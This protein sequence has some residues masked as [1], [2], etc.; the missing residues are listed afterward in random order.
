MDSK[1]TYSKPDGY[2][3]VQ[4]IH[5]QGKHTISTLIP[6]CIVPDS[7]IIRLNKMLNEHFCNSEELVVTVL[8]RNASL[9][10]C[11]SIGM[12]ISRAQLSKKVL[13]FKGTLRKI[14]FLINPI[15]C[16]LQSSKQIWYLP[17]H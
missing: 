5:A 9:L 12:I 14:G 7:T 10:I 8:Q 17:L 16:Y 3:A 13:L 2:I 4:T 11:V 6:F 15:I 1:S